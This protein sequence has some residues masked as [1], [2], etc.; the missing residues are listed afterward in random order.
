MSFSAAELRELSLKGPKVGARWREGI[1]QLPSQDP[2]R[3]LQDPVGHG[4][5][6]YNAGPGWN[7]P[8]FEQRALDNLAWVLMLRT[9]G[10]RAMAQQIASFVEAAFSDGSLL[11]AVRKA[12]PFYYRLTRKER[13]GIPAPS[14][15]RLFRLAVQA[16]A[17]QVQPARC[18][19]LRRLSGDSWPRALWT[20]EGEE[21]TSPNA[22]VDEVGEALMALAHCKM[23]SSALKLGDLVVQRWQ[24]GKLAKGE[25]AQRLHRLV[26]GLCAADH[27]SCAK[28][29]RS[30]KDLRLDLNHAPPLV[31]LAAQAKR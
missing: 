23:K 16:R 31:A 27:P 12:D 28:A 3:G 30:T 21:A 6:R 13:Q 20:E 7:R 11:A 24:Q 25:K 19:L 10:K 4:V 15:G 5:F 14:A 22:P 17:A 1:D 18:R 9:L 2:F 29:L 26:A 8:H